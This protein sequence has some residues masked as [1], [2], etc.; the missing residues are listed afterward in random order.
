[1]KTHFFYIS[2]ANHSINIIYICLKL[3]K[4][5][6]F[7]LKK[8]ITFYSENVKVY[9]IFLKI[10]KLRN[11]PLPN[12]FELIFKLYIMQTLITVIQTKSHV[13]HNSNKFTMISNIYLL[14]IHHC[15]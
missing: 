6:L 3:K 15:P 5:G 9:Y 11:Q 7:N 2:H 4:M 1:M 12:F 14:S 8:W 10:R 13:R